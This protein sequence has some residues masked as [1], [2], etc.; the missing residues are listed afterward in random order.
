VVSGLYYVVP[1]KAGQVDNFVT[2]AQSAGGWRQRYDG[3]DLS[4]DVRAGRGLRILAGTSTG[5][6]I[7][8]NCGV[9]SRLPE[10]STAVAGTSAFGAGLNGS[11]VTPLSPYCDVRY[12]LLTQVRGL[13]AY[14]VPKIDL[15][16]AA[17]FQSKPGALLAA[18]Y[19]VPNREVAPS[20]GRN[21]SGN[22]ANVTVNLIEPGTLY[23]DRITQ[24]D[25]RLGRLIRPGRARL[26]LAVDT[27][28]ALNSNAVL[29]Y[30]STYVPG[31][32]WLQPISVLT[33]RFVKLSAELE[34]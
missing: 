3:L 26:L 7:A 27:Y 12:G 23:G 16:V 29:S 14:T 11:A 32:P 10:L 2:S 5:Q 8:E 4:V 22:A 33:P 25:L 6:T 1:G 17:T 31:G 20:L 34:F 21:L 28:N 30:D 24:L 18:N 15:Q 19:A 13:A 9:R